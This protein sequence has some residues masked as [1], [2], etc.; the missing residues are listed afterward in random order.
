MR[1][2]SKLDRLR[3]EL[4]LAEGKLRARPSSATPMKDVER[5]KRVL[6]SEERA[7]LEAW[8]AETE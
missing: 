1:P 3:L 6:E 5:C 2:A 7:T 8:Q 4:A